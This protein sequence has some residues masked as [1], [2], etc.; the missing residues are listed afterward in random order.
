M[1]DYITTDDATT[2]DVADDTV[3]DLIDAITDYVFDDDSS[4]PETD[5]PIDEDTD[6]DTVAG[7]PARYADDWFEQ[8]TDY[9][10]APSSVAQIVAEYTG[11][12]I[13]NESEFADYAAQHGILTEDG[14]T[15][16]NTAE[17]LNAAGIPATLEE[18]S[19]SELSDYLDSGYGVMVAVD[20]GYWDP[21]QEAADEAAGTDDGADHCVVVSAIDDEYVYLSDTGNPDGNM[22]PVPIADFEAAWAESGNTL[23][24]CDEPA[25]GV[26][27]DDVVAAASSTDESAVVDAVTAAGDRA[28]S[29]FSTSDAIDWATAHPWILLPITLAAGA[30]VSPIAGR[31]R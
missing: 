8:S 3:H 22:L 18:G 12:D 20:S 6:D 4:A 29:E 1:S 26:D 27:D 13:S 10:C 9:T 2:D 28:D 5:V 7:D 23:I 15:M 11:E 21:A 14:M 24:R 17:L 25:P 16:D 31:N 30:A 19:M